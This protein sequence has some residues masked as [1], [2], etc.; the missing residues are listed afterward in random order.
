MQLNDDQYALV[1]ATIMALKPYGST[2]DKCSDL[3]GL[4]N[5]LQNSF[6]GQ[7]DDV[8][9]KLTALSNACSAKNSN[10][11]LNALNDLFNALINL[12]PSFGC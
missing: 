2:P 12:F 1:Q 5:D 11:F 9:S 3:S 10:S 7:I 6:L 8:S 4:I